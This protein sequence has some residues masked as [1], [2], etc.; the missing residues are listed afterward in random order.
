[1]IKN[2]SLI[3]TWKTSDVIAAAENNDVTI[4]NDDALKVLERVALNYSCDVGV[5]W[6][7]IEEHLNNHILGK[8]LDR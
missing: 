7:V 5:T 8:A 1:M 4:T 2:N 3:I 6:D